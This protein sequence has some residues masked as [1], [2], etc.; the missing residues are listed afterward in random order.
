M[1]ENISDLEMRT[2][3]SFSTLQLQQAASSRHLTQQF[4]VYLVLFWLYFWRSGSLVIHQGAE[5]WDIISTQTAKEGLFSLFW[6]GGFVSKTNI[7]WK[8]SY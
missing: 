1:T 6:C 3:L 4:I 7:V 5:Q 2:G 8:V